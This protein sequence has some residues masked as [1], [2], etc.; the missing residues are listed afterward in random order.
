M[1]FSELLDYSK[2]FEVYEFDDTKD[3]KLYEDT[4]SQD[5]VLNEYNKTK[6][7]N[8]LYEAS[9]KVID[10]I[11]V[12]DKYGIIFE[13][14]PADSILYLIESDP[15][16]SVDLVLE[17]VV[18]QVKMHRIIAKELISQKDYFNHA[19]N[20]CELLSE[21]IKIKLRKLSNDLPD[22][23]MLCHGNF[24]LDNVF[25]AEELKVFGFENAYKGHPI[26]DVAK[27][28]LLYEIP[29][30]LKDGSDTVNKVLE[31]KQEE[32]VESYLQAYKA[33]TNMDLSLLKYYKQL[34]AVVRLNEHKKG[35]EDFLL[36]I[37]N[38]DAQ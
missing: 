36:K 21:D 37:I 12:E 17:T 4:V 27:T 5:A 2:S 16:Q 35:E 13:H 29:R 33:L 7:I 8:R 38:D 9:I 22:A 20:Q 10:H 26:S 31:S 11:A 32:T 30:T 25:K 14:V 18:E 6:I 19:I 3:I 1:R 24:H 34:V 23:H 15:A 28:C